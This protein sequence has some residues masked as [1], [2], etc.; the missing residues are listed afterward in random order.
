[1]LGGT[2]ILEEALEAANEKR[3]ALTAEVARL[4][5]EVERQAAALVDAG[6]VHLADEQSVRNV[7]RRLVRMTAERDALLRA[8]RDVLDAAAGYS[9]GRWDALRA[10]VEA[11][12]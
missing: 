11:C 1:M 9:G 5:A 8:A 7:A 6:A 4:R 10:A 3:A 12:K 2:L